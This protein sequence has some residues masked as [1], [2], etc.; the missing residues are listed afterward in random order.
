MG[1]YYS[2]KGM[3]KTIYKAAGVYR[4]LLGNLYPHKN[5]CSTGSVRCNERGGGCA[6]S[7][8]DGCHPYAFWSGT[9]ITGSSYHAFWEAGGSINTGSRNTTEAYSV[10]CLF[11]RAILVGVLAAAGLYTAFFELCLW[12][13]LQHIS[14]GY[15]A[16]V[17]C[18]KKPYVHFNK[19]I[20]MF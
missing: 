4:L 11:Y 14:L 3:F 18:I 9:H 20:R 16:I 15:T 19:D 5:A 1:C 17:A 2:Y 12:I 8:G 6:G 7:V 10:R 13:Y